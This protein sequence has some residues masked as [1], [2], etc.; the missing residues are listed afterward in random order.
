ML[1]R[2]LQI[3]QSIYFYFLFASILILLPMPQIRKKIQWYCFYHYLRVI[4]KINYFIHSLLVVDLRE[5]SRSLKRY[6]IG[7]NIQWYWFLCVLYC[8]YYIF[9]NQKYC[10]T[11]CVPTFELDLVGSYIFRFFYFS[12]SH[13]HYMCPYYI[14]QKYELFFVLCSFPILTQW[15][16]GFI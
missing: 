2:T 6:L 11:C 9:L 14:K 1:D 7:W 3:N 5:T 8:R 10:C 16:S 15:M 12:L 13:L 4:K